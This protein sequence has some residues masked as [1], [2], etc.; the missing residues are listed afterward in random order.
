MLTTLI[1]EVQREQQAW[2]KQVQ[3]MERL[4][5]QAGLSRAV[6]S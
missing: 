2:F 5:E 6:F 3:V 1:E 4:V